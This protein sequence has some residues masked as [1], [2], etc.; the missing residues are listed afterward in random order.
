M[1]DVALWLPAIVWGAIFLWSYRREPRQF[2]NAFF[3][4][5]FCACTL[6]AAAVYFKQWWITLP[7]ALAVAFTPVITIV[8]M[9]VN[10]VMLVKREG[11]SLSHALPLLFACTI[12]AWFGALPVAHAARLPGVVVGFV[13][14][15]TACG[16]WFFLSFAALLVYSWLY[17]SLPRRRRYDFIII[18]GAGLK[19]QELTPLLAGRVERAYELW[20]A[21][22]RRATLVPSG[23]QGEDEEI[24]EAEA[25]A[26]HLRA[27]GVPPTQL[28]LEDRS[29]TTWENLSFSRDLIAE[30]SSA[31]DPRS[32][33]V[34][35]DYHV[36]RAAMYA[37]AV[38]LNADGLGSRT[39][40]YYIP[41]AFIR[42]FI[43]ISR[44]YWW[45]YATIMGLWAAF[46]L[47]FLTFR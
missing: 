28:A 21:Q 4:F 20:N 32:A 43:A 10:E 24:S 38:G 16:A 42:E 11:F 36:F 6:G 39:A 44:R 37:R 25:M 35:S 30:R 17:R 19:G 40:R 7:I 13:L 22:G 41:T 2:R 47:F 27:L 8:F 45:P 31:P 33:L 5:F 34:T 12:V 46:T 18:H 26:R 14:A 29:T 23:G 9:L 15:V 1:A 3:F